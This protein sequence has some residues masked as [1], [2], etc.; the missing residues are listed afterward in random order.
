MKQRFEDL[1]TGFCSLKQLGDPEPFIHGEPINVNGVRCTLIYNEQ[2]NSDQMYMYIAFDYAPHEQEGAIY[3]LLLQ[4][5]HTGFAGKG[6]GF[7]ISPTTGM[8]GYVIRIDLDEVTPNKL[9]SS[10]TYY[11]DKAIEWKETFF[12]DKRAPGSRRPAFI[13]NMSTSAN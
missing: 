5:N 11:A 8:V 3:K 9:A 10:L 6:P 7:C 4:Q 1:V 13:G 12:L 2:I